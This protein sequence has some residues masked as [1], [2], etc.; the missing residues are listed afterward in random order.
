METIPL[1]ALN[2][3]EEPANELFPSA[4]L[5]LTL[6]LARFQRY[7]PRV[8]V[9]FCFSARQCGIAVNYVSGLE[10]FR[11]ED[12]NPSTCIFKVLL[13]IAQITPLLMFNPP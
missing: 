9:R 6:I 5:Y 2:I 1:I 7:M 4:S 10:Y 3:M 13:S 11:E 8:R 12:N